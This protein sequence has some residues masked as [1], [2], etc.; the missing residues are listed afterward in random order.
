MN[1][2]PVASFVTDAIDPQKPTGAGWPSEIQA[3]AVGELLH[4]N[5]A[6]H[7]NEIGIS[8]LQFCGW[9]LV[10]GVQDCIG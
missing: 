2:S 1:G 3:A 6:D 4:L 8:R 9:I 10:R 5:L 7:V